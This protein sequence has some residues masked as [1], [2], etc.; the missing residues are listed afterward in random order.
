M[1]EQVLSAGI[2]DIKRSNYLYSIDV[3][4]D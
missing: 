3:M 1:A 4:T 2:K